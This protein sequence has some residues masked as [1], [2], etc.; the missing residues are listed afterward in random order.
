V[1][2]VALVF[3]FELGDGTP[4]VLPPLGIGYIASVLDQRR[5]GRSIV[6]CTFSGIDAAIE[7][8]RTERP[9]VVGVYSMVTLGQS[10]RRVARELRGSVEWLVAGG[11]LPTAYPESFLEEFDIVVLGEADFA[12][13][14]LVS[15]LLAGEGPAGVPGVVRREGGSTVTGGPP[16]N[17]S[18]LDSVPH[19]ARAEF[20]NTRYMSYWTEHFGYAPASIVATRG[21][22][23][24]CDFC[25]RPVSGA[26]FRARSPEDVV[27]EA[28]EV[29]A[30][31]YRHLW[32][33]D[34]AFTYDTDLVLAICDGLEGLGVRWDCLSRVDR[35]DD[36]LVAAMA[37]AGLHKVYLGVESGSDATLRLMRK[38]TTVAEA[39]SAIKTFAAHGVRTAGFF[40]VGYPGETLPDAWS[41]VEMSALAGLDE[42]SFT[43]PYPLPGSP[44]HDRYRAYIDPMREWGRERENTP[45]IETGI[46]EAALK[47][48]IETATEAHRLASGGRREEAVGLLARRRR[49]CER[50][51]GEHEAAP[52]AQGQGLR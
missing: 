35:I 22:P 44:L 8:I 48:L 34:D 52:V 23:Y 40:M 15:R 29:R 6:D 27:A 4:W 36:D 14:A 12:F 39:R 24:T 13:P 25:S 41:T 7:R 51:V 5:I 42:V 9:R 18:D 20:P 16:V 1:A 37:R 28:A 17:V 30:L 47:T 10:A 21:C 46:P 38:G 50:M 43:V 26:D 2:D 49:E 45:F 3:P 19:P 11:P 31:G 32:F 33:A